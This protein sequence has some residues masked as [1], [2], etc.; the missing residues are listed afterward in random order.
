MILMFSLNRP[1]I[2]PVGDLGIRTA[3]SK[4]YKI[5]RENKEEILKI[6][7]SWSPHRTLASRYLWKSLG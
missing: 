2:F 6:S 1:D 7:E 3:M 5:E 4:L